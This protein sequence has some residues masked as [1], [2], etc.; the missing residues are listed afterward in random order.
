MQVTV[1]PVLQTWGALPNLPW[2][3]GLIDTIATPLRAI[4]G[5][6][7]RPRK[8]TNCD[9]EWVRGPG[10]DS[11]RVLLYLHGGAFI[12]CGLHTHRRLV[13]RISAV[14]KAPALSVDYRMLPENPIT[15]SIE[16]CL[17]G[18]QLLLDLGYRNDQIVIVG[19]SA[20]GYMALMTAI[21][22]NERGI[23]YPAAVVCQ[24]PFVDTDP[25]RKLERL[26]NVRDPLFPA[27]GL[28]SLAELMTK[29]E[30]ERGHLDEYGRVRRPLDADLSGMPPVL[31]QAGAD[32]LLVVDAELIATEIAD[33]G[34]ECTLQLFE[35]QF[36]VFQAA[37]DLIPEGQ[38]AIDMIGEFVREHVAG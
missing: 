5:S 27:N 3:Y 36:H 35:G 14:C 2:P 33:Q 20:G 13:S 21:V 1:R 17:D 23:G 26:G 37:A 11:D 9:A 34:A 6:T 8:L 19:D 30:G 31:I 12:C 32:E 28:M 24:S 15:E 25:E 18:Y 16:D 7:V 4:G 29:V 10:A 38:Q 22:A